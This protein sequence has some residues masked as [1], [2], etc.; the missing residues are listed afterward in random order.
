M[1]AEEKNKIGR[2]KSATQFEEKIKQFLQNLEF[3]DVDGARDNFLING[4]QVDVCGGWENAL[5]VIECKT[6]QKLGKK[7]LR[8]V[9][10]EFHGKIPLLERGFK[11]HPTYKNTVFLN[12]SLLQKT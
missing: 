9:I 2:K 5:L 8:S 1:V 10:S 4:V 7:N 6:K 3:N 11:Q 12:I